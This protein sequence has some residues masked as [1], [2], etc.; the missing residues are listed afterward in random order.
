[1]MVEFYLNLQR[2]VA[3]G[4]INIRSVQRGRREVEGRV[5]VEGAREEDDE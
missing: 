2:K 1:M 4:R 3:V 5:G